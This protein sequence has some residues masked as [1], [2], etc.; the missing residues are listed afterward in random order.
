MR[1]KIAIIVLFLFIV[2]MINAQDNNGTND[3]TKNNISPQ[4]NKTDQTTDKKKK[5]EKRFQ[6]GFGVFVNSNDMYTLYQNIMRYKAIKN[7]KDYSYPALSHRE[8]DAL[9]STPKYMQETVLG[10]YG[11]KTME[12]GVQLRL[13]WNYLISETDFTFLPVDYSNN[14]RTDLMLTPMIGVRYP[15]F[16]MPYLMIGPNFSYGFNPDKLSDINM[17]NW[18][19]KINSF[20]NS[21][22]FTVGIASKAGVDLKFD[23]F[24]VGLYYQFRVKDFADLNYWYSL[25]K[26][27]DISGGQAFANALGQSSRFGISAVLYIF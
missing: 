9:L 16:I 21:G 13:L 15:Y 3:Q 4:S 2:Y 19:T 6:L 14:L 26:S 18:K 10:E 12:Y 25:Y 8:R 17:N 11:F 24:S 23:N 5:D 7:G 27:G 22:I 1:M 20:N